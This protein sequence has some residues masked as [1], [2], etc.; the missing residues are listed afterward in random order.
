MASRRAST[1]H[2]VQSEFGFHVIILDDVQPEAPKFEDVKPAGRDVVQRKKLQEYL[3]GP[4]QDGRKFRSSHRPVK[5]TLSAEKPA[6]REESRLFS[7]GR[8]RP[9]PTAPAAQPRLEGALT[10]ALE[11]FISELP[12]ASRCSR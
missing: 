2:A 8:T 6:F 1:R 10:G 12:T 9:P 4:S 3:D 7:F 11:S 5:P